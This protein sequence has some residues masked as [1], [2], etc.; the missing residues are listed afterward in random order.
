MF[1]TRTHFGQIP[2]ET[3]KKI[4]EEQIRRETT[5]DQDQGTQRKTL[6][7]VQ[8]GAQELSTASSLIFS[9]VE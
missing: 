2:L 1:K 9:Q 7:E 8:S 3:V 4:V 6:E 5:I